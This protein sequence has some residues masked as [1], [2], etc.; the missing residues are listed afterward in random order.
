VTVLWLAGFEHGSAAWLAL[1]N[2]DARYVS[3]AQG[4]AVVSTDSH[5]GTYCAELDAVAGVSFDQFSVSTAILGTQADL[6]GTFYVKFFTSLPT[7]DC[8]V[9]LMGNSVSTDDQRLRFR[10]SDSK[11]IVDPGNSGTVRVGPVVTTNTWY[12]IDWSWNGTTTTCTVKWAVDG[13]AQT[14]AT[15][16]VASA[17]NSAGIFYGFDSNTPTG[18][19]R[20]DDL[21]ITDNAADHPL[22]QHK[23]VILTADTGGTATQVGTAN[24][25]ARFTTNGG[26][27]DATFSSANILAALAELP[28]TFGATASGVYQRTSGAGNACRVPMTSYTLLSGETITGVRGEFPGWAATTTASNWSI[29]GDDG[30]TPVV[31]FGLADPNFDN[32]STPAGISRMF[33]S[34]SGGWDQTKLNAL[35]FEVGFATDISPLTGVHACYAEVAVKVS[36]A[37]NSGTAAVV[38]DL[39]VAAVGGRSAGGVAAVGLGLAVVAT[40]G[41]ASRG[42]AAVGLGQAVNAV[43][44]RSSA[45]AAGVGLGLAPAGAGGRPSAGSADTGLGLAPSGSG[46]RISLGSSDVGLGLAPAG[47]GGRAARGAAALGVELAPDATGERDSAGAAALGLGLAV[48]GVGGRDSAGS[49]ALG[50]ELDVA[51]FAGQVALGHL[52]VGLDLAVAATGSR[53]SSGSAALVL[54]LALATVGARAARGAAALGLDLAAAGAGQ[55]DSEGVAAL[56][57]ALTVDA[58]GPPPPPRP[59]KIVAAGSSPGATARGHTAATAARGTTGS[60]TAR[61]G[62]EDA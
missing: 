15:C 55:R 41:R 60:I 11:L 24:A 17:S 14:D 52:D 29:D 59:S 16:T 32:T 13:S 18:H 58:A 53:P 43:G 22:G 21:V 12:R 45:G 30:A 28:P 19:M 5:S 33:T 23:V 42:V 56:G 26:G 9:L 34:A 48:A 20:F 40:G 25:T 10:A 7:A 46:A 37:P 50:I 31:L 62:Y 6:A 4:V 49:S 61:G 3:T 27:L 2:T 35:A 47:V 1:G 51:G 36:A 44:G 38:L 54:D 8:D 57:L 39:A